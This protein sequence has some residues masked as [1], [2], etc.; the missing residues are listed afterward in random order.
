MDKI[1]DEFMKFKNN[2]NSCFMNYKNEEIELWINSWINKKEKFQEYIQFIDA[3]FHTINN[4]KQVNQLLQKFL[5]N[6]S[7]SSIRCLHFLMQTNYVYEHFD[8]VSLLSQIFSLTI[9]LKEDIKQQTFI[10]FEHFKE[11]MLENISNINKETISI[12]EELSKLCFDIHQKGGLIIFL[13]TLINHKQ[14]AIIF[15]IELPLTPITISIIFHSL[16]SGIKYFE[17]TPTSIQFN[18]FP[19]KSLL[20]IP[21]KPINSCILP[22]NSSKIQKEPNEE[23]FDFQSYLKD[24]SFEDHSFQTYLVH[25]Y[26]FFHYCYLSELQFFHSR[27]LSLFSKS[28]MKL[29]S[30]IVSMFLCDLSNH[31]L[32]CYFSN[33]QDFLFYLISLP[34]DSKF[35]TVFEELIHFSSILLYHSVIMPKSILSRFNNHLQ[36][37][38]TSLLSHFEILPLSLKGFTLKF[39]VQ[40]LPHF[41]KVTS[42][43]VIDTSSFFPVSLQMYLLQLNKSCYSSSF[44]ILRF[45]AP[46]PFYLVT[47]SSLQLAI[48]QSVGSLLSTLLLPF[49]SNLLLSLITTSQEYLSACLSGTNLSRCFIDNITRMVEAIDFV[50]WLMDKQDLTDDN[51]LSL[52]L[53]VDSLIMLLQRIITLREIREPFKHKFVRSLILTIVELETLIQLVVDDVVLEDSQCTIVNASLHYINWTHLSTEKFFVCS[54]DLNEPQWLNWKSSKEVFDT[55]PALPQ[56]NSLCLTVSRI[57]SLI[58]PQFHK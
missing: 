13:R 35:F 57:A 26:Y 50:F 15:P 18:S 44:Y 12:F 21:P 34:L 36:T 8:V 29:S 16:I 27:S 22:C 6:K 53:L 14:N 10:N 4:Y 23:E 3:L 51:L 17:Q 45:I 11:S 43:Q 40:C 25:L 33:L 30:Q 52:H 32:P 58:Q 5:H 39:L 56:I 55:T 42:S 46:M 38:V 48:F 2:N 31:I 37:L 9:S 1:E 19:L 20:E 47:G 54:V 7:L 49:K 41:I 28:S 24:I